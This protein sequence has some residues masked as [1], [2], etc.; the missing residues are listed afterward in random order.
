M[1]IILAAALALFPL[2]AAVHYSHT[3]G[4]VAASFLEASAV[5]PGPDYTVYVGDAHDYQ[6]PRVA[7]DETGAAYVAG[8]RLIPYGTALLADVYIAKLDRTG[9]AVFTASIG[10]KGNDTVRAIAVDAAH[11]IYVAGWTTSGNFPLRNPLQSQPASGGG[12]L[13][14]LSSDGSRL[15]FSTYFNGGINAL[16]VDRSENV[17]LTGTTGAL[18]F[19]VTQGMPSARLRPQGPNAVYGAF[20]TKLAPAGD[21][22][23]YSGVIAGYSVACGSGSSCFLSTRNTSGIA[24]GV[25]GQGQAIVAGNTNTTDLPATPGALRTQGIGAFV[26]K[27]N[28]AGSGLVYLTLLGSENYV[29]APYAGP[30]NWLGGLAVDAAGHAYLAGATNDP[31]FPATAGSFQPAYSGGSDPERLPAPQRDAFAARL[32]PDGGSMVWATF[33][34]GAEADEAHAVSLDSSGNVWINGTTQSASFPG[35][36]S[37]AQ[38]PDFIAA[39]RPGGQALH[40]AARFP[41]ATVSQDL[42]VDAAGIV[43]AAGPL[44]LLSALDPA[45]PAAMRLLGI[46]NAAAGSLGG[47]IAPGE[48]ISIYGTKLGPS[49]GA[50]SVPDASGRIPSS[51]AGVQVLVDDL[52]AP[53]L[54]V[55]ESQINAVVPF[56]VRNRDRVRVRVV[57]QDAAA[58]DF[59][60]Y[61]VPALPEIFRK[62]WGAAAIN[63]DGTVNS[64]DNPAPLGSIV[65]IWASG[66]GAVSLSDGEIPQAAMN[67]YCCSIDLNSSPAE[68]LYAGVAP[69][70]VAGVSQVNFRLPAE[71][72]SGAKDVA[73]TLTAGGRGSSPAVI[74][75]R[76][77]E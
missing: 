38:G 26:A 75:V 25:D 12:F 42:A 11:N 20:I 30:A 17:Y 71:M 22:I 15:I 14:K 52:P 43:H 57:Y 31:N 48:L 9:A 8:Q 51:L 55:S 44:G 35:T 54:Y 1:K 39:F 5:S 3:S 47:R 56:G 28:S 74:Y 58:A 21:R 18:D 59:G 2:S 64:P 29:V 10:G 53:L 40:Y 16:A 36:Q 73:V 76:T 19:P 66:A 65:A 62:P 46:G 24:I 69:G 49:Q 23:L 4:E 70:M 63:Q 34:G 7:V 41:G 72:Y 37:L 33:L 68:V 32:A 67:T 27:V 50:V 45:Q 13:L 6:L 77:A 60:A 61:V